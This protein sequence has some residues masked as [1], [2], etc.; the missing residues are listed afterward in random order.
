M[1]FTP[2]SSL[3]ALTNRNLI[4]YVNFYVGLSLTRFMLPLGLALG[5]THFL[6]QL[7]F[8]WCQVRVFVI[9]FDRFR[10]RG[11]SAGSESLLF[12]FDET[13]GPGGGTGSKSLLFL[14]DETCGGGGGAGS[15]SLSSVSWTKTVDLEAGL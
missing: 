13:G 4:T 11:G 7:D 8:G 12:L 2:A 14:F 9:L 1:T 15:E 10:G 5:R 3:G 6:F